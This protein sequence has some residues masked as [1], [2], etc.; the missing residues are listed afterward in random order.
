M[1]SID[2]KVIFI[3]RLYLNGGR[4]NM[5]I[6]IVEDDKM[7]ANGIKLALESVER[8]F[9][10]VTSLKEARAIL[11]VE[12]I[13]LIILDINLP[14]GSGLTLL[15]EIKKQNDI[16]VLVLTANDLELDII[17][18]FDLGADDYVTKPVS[19]MALRA[20]VDARI[21]GLK[22][23]GKNQYSKGPFLF[24]YDSLIFKVEENIIGLSKMEQK[25]LIKMV[26][27][28]NQVL[29]RDDLIDFM[30]ANE[31][32]FVELNALS[33]LISRLRQKLSI[34]KYKGEDYLK[35]IHGI[36]YMWE[37]LC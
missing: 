26:Q 37:V 24:D 30:W 27:N 33:V 7:L 6:L 10:Q 8:N 11:G 21:R 36:G 15:E 4:G 3:N 22:I 34:G 35:T 28:E 16:P 18:A 13:D 5:K 20:R 31:G 12:V 17:T 2:I 9:V 19:L 1:H 32:E 14:D 29:T 25:I 23:V